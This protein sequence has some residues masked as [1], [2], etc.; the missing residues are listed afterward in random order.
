MIIEIIQHYHEFKVVKHSETHYTVEDE[1]G[2]VYWETEDKSS[3][4]SFIEKLEV[5]YEDYMR[6]KKTSSPLSNEKGPLIH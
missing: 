3:A 1:D 4:I 5:K 2:T 6:S